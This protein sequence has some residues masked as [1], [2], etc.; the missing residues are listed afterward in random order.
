MTC[1]N[2]TPFLRIYKRSMRNVKYHKILVTHDGSECAS[3]I[4][5]HVKSLSSFL[6]SKILLLRV[7]DPYVWGVDVSG[8]P[9]IGLFAS[10]VT[11]LSVTQLANETKK[12]AKKELEEVKKELENMGVRKIEARVIDGYAPEIIQ[13]II[14][15]EKIDLIMMAT[16]GRTGLKKVLIG[17]VTEQIIHSATCPVY[18]VKPSRAR[19]RKGVK[20]NE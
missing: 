17:S 10:A 8:V 11:P 14:K 12:A 20:N 5:P 15:K 1:I 16:H 13:Y 19:L 6:K 2:D 7:I 3:A 9:D 18:T 4:L